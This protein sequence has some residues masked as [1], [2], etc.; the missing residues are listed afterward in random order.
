MSQTPAELFECGVRDYFRDFGHRQAREAPHQTWLT[1]CVSKYINPQLIVAELQAPCHDVGVFGGMDPSKGALNFDFA[2]TRAEMDL[3]TW[4]TRTPG[5]RSGVSTCMQTLTTLNNVA[6][7]AELKIAKST[8]TKTASLAKD[9]HKLTGAVRFLESQGCHAFPDCY[10]VI[11]DPERVLDIV[12]AT[13]IVQ[14]DWP[15]DKP[16]PKLLVGP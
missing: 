13:K 5:W 12:R 11:L 6:V 15:V 3:R 10:F 9:L 1:I 14:D 7:L 4:K 8:S 2:I 16:F